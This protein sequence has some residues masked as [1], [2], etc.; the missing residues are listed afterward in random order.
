MWPDAT[1]RLARLLRAGLAALLHATAV[2]A[3]PLHAGEG[4]LAFG[5]DLGRPGVLSPDPHYPRLA[6]G[7]SRRGDIVWLSA[8]DTM[9]AAAA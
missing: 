7:A 9:S 8:T 5:A 2:Y 1:L 4:P 3:E 6:P